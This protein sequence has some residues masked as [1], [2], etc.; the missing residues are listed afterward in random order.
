M[1]NTIRSRKKSSQ[2]GLKLPNHTQIL[3]SLLLIIFGAAILVYGAVQEMGFYHKPNVTS[4][5]SG[6]NLPTPK[7][8]KLYIPRL[9]RVLYVSDGYVQGDRWI[10]SETG[11][12]YLVTSAVPGEI[13]NAVIYGHNTK[14]ILGGLW[15]VQDGDTIYVVLQSGDFVKYQVSEKKEIEPTQVEILNQTSDSRLTIYTCSGFLDT[16]RF[17]VVARETETV[18]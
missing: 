11:V 5:A 2:K 7:P 15:R 3:T 16:A 9:S 10:I 17:V 8:T 13:G 4:V 12:S 1:A 6:S 18:I 14:N